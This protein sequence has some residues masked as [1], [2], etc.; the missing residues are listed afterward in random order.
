[1]LSSILFAFHW[2]IFAFAF[3]QTE[4]TAIKLGAGQLL[5]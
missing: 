1:V 4:A 2:K 3:T 5:L